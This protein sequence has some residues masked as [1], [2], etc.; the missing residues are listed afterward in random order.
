MLATHK[1]RAK[2]FATRVGVILCL[3]AIF[4]VGVAAQYLQAPKVGGTSTFDTPPNI[5]GNDISPLKRRPSTLAA[6][7][8]IGTRHREVGGIQRGR[9]GEQGTVPLVPESMLIPLA[10]WRV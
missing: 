2:R 1:L 7:L 8:Q 10:G 4:E 9:G 5:S 3:G 6:M